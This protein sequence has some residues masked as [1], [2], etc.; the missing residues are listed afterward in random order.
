MFVILLIIASFPL[1]SAELIGNEYGFA[2]AWFNGQEAT[3][4]NTKLKIGEPVDIKVT[5]TSNVSGHVFV[6]LTNPLVTEPYS[7]TNG[8]TIIGESIDNY[9]V[10]SGWSK[11]YIWTIAPNGAWKNGN[12]P[13]NVFIQFFNAQKKQS[14]KIEFTI[15]NPY[16]LDEQYT[17]AAQTPGPTGTAPGTTTPKA[18]PFPPALG[19][20]AML[21]VVWM[22]RRRDES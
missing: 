19:V 10:A 20:I 4:K 13:I 15:A 6:K 18:A 12:A 16:I 8:P 1:A 9:D 2:N 5:V 22:W 7:V 11:T 3:V 21:L 17:G 14:K